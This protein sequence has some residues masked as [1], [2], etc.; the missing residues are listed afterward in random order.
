ML[1]QFFWATDSG[2]SSYVF[3]MTVSKRS[4][5]ENAHHACN[6]FKS[7]SNSFSTSCSELI[8]KYINVCACRSNVP[9]A[10]WLMNITRTTNYWCSSAFLTLCCHI[11]EPT[12]TVLHVKAPPHLRGKQGQCV[13]QCRRTTKG[14]LTYHNRNKAE[15]SWYTKKK[16]KI[17]IQKIIK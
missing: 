11:F 8:V 14:T 3:T 7:L 2:L 5:K 16:K 17:E 15:L 12:A 9:S 1:L 6:I 4:H 10:D 13:E